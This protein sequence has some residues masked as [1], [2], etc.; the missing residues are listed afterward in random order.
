M[1]DPVQS[2]QSVPPLRALL[3]GAGRRPNVLPEA[4]RLRPIIERH[5][6]IVA[7]DFTGTADMSTQEADLAIVLGGDGA[8][9]RAAHQMGSRQLPVVAVNLGRLGFLA[10]LTPAELPEVLRDF[11]A[12]KLSRTEHLMFECSVIRS[13][14][15]ADP[16][17]E[18][19]CERELGLNEVVIWNGP[20]FSM[21][22]LDLYIDSELVTTYSCDG[23]ILST[24]VGS[25][26]HSLSAGG[27]ILRKE[28]QAL[29]ICP[30]SP[31]ALTNRPVVDS[32]DRVYEMVVSRPNVGT[33]VVL[34]GRVVCTL[35][36]G[37]R[38]RVTRAEPKFQL[39]AAPGH[40][41]Y[42]TLR[43]K[44]GWGGRLQLNA[45]EDSP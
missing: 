39:V 22:E 12:G 21:M 6:R 25:T 2:L 27:P 26:A 23:L 44:L 16:Q 38:V 31:H 7:E 42:R 20:T 30:I 8:I 36:P 45:R 35:Q 37:D 28:L 33:S 11:A 15:A 43:E 13:D 10:D 4:E 1:S 19:P 9:L 14:E 34:D 29:A 40:S 32:A 17:A 18:P 5:A 3:L 24:P 41:Y